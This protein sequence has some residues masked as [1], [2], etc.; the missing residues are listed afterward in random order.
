MKK[1]QLVKIK[2]TVGMLQHNRKDLKT[3][4]SHLS[5]EAI[6]IIL[7]I[8]SNI[9]FNNKVLNHLGKKKSF[10]I[11]QKK[12]KL[13][14]KKWENILTKPSSANTRKKFILTQT[15]AGTPKILETIL[16]FLPAL[17]P[18]ILI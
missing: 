2:N 18:L 8:I 11:L 4:I 7:E 16:Q 5:D 9:V 1:S 12:M 15:G 6:H 14:Q 3:M 17:L 10:K 13:Q